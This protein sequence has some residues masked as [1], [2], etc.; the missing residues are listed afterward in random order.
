MD[1]LR[2]RTHYRRFVL[3]A[4]LSLLAGPSF[5]GSVSGVV[6]YE[7]PVPELKPI[8][9]QSDPACL[10]RHA[11][12]PPNEMLVLGSGNTMGNVLVR[13]RS[14]ASGDFSP[15][16]EPVTLDQVGCQF[17]PHVLAV[18][19]DQ[20]LTIR[21]SDGLLH[22]VRALPKVNPGFQQAMPGSGQEV[23]RSFSK[24]EPPFKIQCDVHPWMAA[25]VAVLDNPYY[26]VT[27]ADG[28][29]N[30]EG[31]P[32]G[33]YEIEAWHEKLK[34]KSAKITIQGDEAA[35]VDFSF[36]PPSR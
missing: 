9:M 33:A 23:T 24:T 25:Y 18:M 36:S 26:D 19:A 7:G 17:V 3:A 28:K 16:E 20:P 1:S 15:P 34:T 10:E 32:P 30:L 22:E 13:V 12:P 6:T 8:Q 5:G 4:L 35:K 11:S 2:Q 29:F 27:G 31:L 21:N 14:G